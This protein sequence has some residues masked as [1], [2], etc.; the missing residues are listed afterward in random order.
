LALIFTIPTIVVSI[1]LLLTNIVRDSRSQSRH[2]GTAERRCSD[3]R[4]QRT[5]PTDSIEIHR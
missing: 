4:L 2:E 3:S 5:R 1:S